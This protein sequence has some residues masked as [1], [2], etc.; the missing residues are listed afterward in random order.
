MKKLIYIVITLLTLNSCKAQENTVMNNKIIIP[1]VTKEFETFDINKFNKQK[2]NGQ[3]IINTD[4]ELQMFIDYANGYNK[5][6]YIVNSSFSVVKNFYL[7]G[8]IEIKGVRFNNGSEYGIWY[9]FNEEG[10][11]IKEIN[12]DQGY[13]F[14]WD[15]VLEYCEN[16]SIILDRGYPK[17]GGIKTEIFKNEEEGNKVWNITYYNYK[18]EQYLSLTLDG[19][20]GELTKEQMIDFEGN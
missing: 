5:T 14:G 11:L 10:K 2:I 19:I 9:E 15:K 7:N 6:T 3:V 18:K 17:K 13:I 20:T 4:D 8:N 16:N 12:M 1:E